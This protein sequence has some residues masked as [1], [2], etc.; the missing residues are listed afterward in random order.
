VGDDDF[1]LVDEPVVRD[2]IRLTDGTRT[3]TEIAAGADGSHAPE[4]VHFVL[5]SLQDQ[6]IIFQSDDPI[7]PS[8]DL[9]ALAS[10]TPKASPTHP[11]L[12]G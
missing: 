6:E 8:D 7:H 10:A 12:G 5:L 2:V 4:I 3:A 1:V 9:G 11:E